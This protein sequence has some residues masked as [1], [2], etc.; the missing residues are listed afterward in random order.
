M[1][2]KFN[3]FTMDEIHKISTTKTESGNQI[4]G[5][6]IFLVCVVQSDDL[7]LSNSFDELILAHLLLN[8]IM[9]SRMCACVL[10]RLT[11]AVCCV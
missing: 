6:F 11:V 1:S 4:N 8:S 5:V 9:F 3:G 7:S 2:N 10:Q